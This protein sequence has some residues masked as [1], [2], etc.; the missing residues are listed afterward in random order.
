MPRSKRS[1]AFSKNNIS[2]LN[3]ITICQ[4]TVLG[5]ESHR[6]VCSVGNIY[7]VTTRKTKHNTDFGG[8]KIARMWELVEFFPVY[9]DSNSN[10]APNLEGSLAPKA[11]CRWQRNEFKKRHISDY[12]AWKPEK[13]S[14]GLS[15]EMNLCSS[16]QAS[17]IHLNRRFQKCLKRHKQA[18]VFQITYALPETKSFFINKED[19]HT[20]VIR[21][22]PNLRK[23]KYKTEAP[24]ICQVFTAA[25]K[26]VKGL[27]GKKSTRKSLQIVLG[28]ENIPQSTEKGPAS[29]PQVLLNVP[30]K[31]SHKANPNLSRD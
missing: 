2:H 6:F 30:L 19:A 26:P 27:A 18:S 29:S 23:W 25:L 28:S 20:E 7:S 12:N 15:L 5:K 4:L 11:T 14:I 17:K 16:R 9:Y 21:W 24:R 13:Y 1:R 10:W 31:P 3:L 8:K 22:P